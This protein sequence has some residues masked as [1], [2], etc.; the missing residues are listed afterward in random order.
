MTSEYI[1]K[2]CQAYQAC[3][4]KN[5]CVRNKPCIKWSLLSRLFG[6]NRSLL[7]RWKQ[8]LPFN[9]YGCQCQHFNRDVIN[10]PSSLR[11]RETSNFK[12]IPKMKQL[13]SH[14]SNC[15]KYFFFS[16]FFFF[17]L[18]KSTTLRGRLFFFIYICNEITCI[19]DTHKSCLFGVISIRMCKIDM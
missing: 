8:V 4:N 16:F 7:I 2:S 13:K 3:F 9:P 5:A 10:N 6:K 14:W 17:F 1:C 11:R 15:C 19:T 18:K 12:I